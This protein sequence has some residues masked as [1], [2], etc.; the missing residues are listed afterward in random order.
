MHRFCIVSILAVFLSGIFILPCAAEQSLFYW[1]TMDEQKIELYPEPVPVTRVQRDVRI[2]R[3]D[4]AL[5]G[6][7]DTNEA[8]RISLLQARL[9]NSLLGEEAPKGQAF[10]VVHSR[11]E[12]IHPR[13]R[14]EKARLE[15]KV[16]RTMGA[17]TF[18]SGGR[19]AEETE[20]VDV[21]VA[22]QVPRMANHLYALNDGLAYPLHEITRQ[23]PGGIAPQ[24]GLIIP[25]KGQTRD[26]G[27]A[28][29][30]PEETG[31]QALQ[32]FDYSYGSI[33]LPIQG[34]TDQA[35]DADRMIR[36]SLDRAETP[37][38]ELAAGGV[39]LQESFGGERAPSG[40]KW[41]VVELLGRSHSQ[42]RKGQGDIVQFDPLE[43]LWLVTDGGYVHYAASGSVDVQGMLRFAP[44]V[45]QRQQAAFL[46]PEET[47]NM[48]MGVR[49]RNQVVDLGVT[50]NGPLPAPDAIRT[51]VDDGVMEVFLFAKTTLEDK[52]V[53][54]LGINPVIEGRGLEI[55]PERQFFLVTEEDEVN[56]DIQATSDLV[57]G[58]P[59]SFVI[60][61]DTPVRFEIAFDTSLDGTAVRIRGFRNEGRIEL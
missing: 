51:W 12:N 38:L 4:K 53:L 10:L 14:M 16:D 22:Y 56:I 2:P 18:A 42:D 19:P 45:F 41:A 8:V 37:L 6:S 60:P 46:V 1:D 31:H 47:K 9:E 57:H 11:W 29:L 17:G 35:R 59:G 7:V 25:E 61:P 24:D 54:D 26:V 36:S 34:Q 52:I 13:Q 23:L 30:V 5:A 3:V 28:F 20:Y 49:I 55:Q 21:D 15:G 39:D 50:R 58:V 48:T 32:F 43:N 44:E 33:T 40:W 27:L